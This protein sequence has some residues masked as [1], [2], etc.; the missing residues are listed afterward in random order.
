[1]SDEFV[2][3]QEYTDSNKSV[4]TRD[5]T[6]MTAVIRGDEVSEGREESSDPLNEVDE[7]GSS[8]Q[9][10]GEQAMVVDQESDDSDDEDDLYERKELPVTL[11]RVLF[12]AC[13]VCIYCGGKFIG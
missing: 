6:S 8:D 5:K 7:E 9:E 3:A 13:D 12:L 4:E 10:G 11:A 2:T 1:M